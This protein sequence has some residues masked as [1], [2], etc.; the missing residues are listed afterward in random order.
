MDKRTVHNKT[1]LFVVMQ[2]NN[3]ND[4]RAKIAIE[5]IE[6][7]LVSVLCVEESG[8][9]LYDVAR[10][11]KSTKKHH[12]GAV[13]QRNPL[14]SCEC[15]WMSVVEIPSSLVEGMPSMRSFNNA[16]FQENMHRAKCTLIICRSNL[17][18]SL[19]RCWPYVL[20]MGKQEKHVDQAVALT[21]KAMKQATQT[22]AYK[23]STSNANV[24]SSKNYHSMAPKSTYN[25][26]KLMIPGWLL[27]DD[28]FLQQIKG[29]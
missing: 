11:F 7:S 16:E 20:V 3:E 27:S 23:S 24:K 15:I 14:N 8:R 26:R 9:F 13:Y 19:L 17:N 29:A 18:A 4:D 28:L 25:P 6:N 12:D 22:L 10:S 1:Q 21:E 2:S 5:T